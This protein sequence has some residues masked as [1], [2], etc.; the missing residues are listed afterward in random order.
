MANVDPP[1]H[2]VSPATG[3]RQ[4]TDVFVL[5]HVAA[6][7]RGYFKSVIVELTEKSVQ[8][9]ASLRNMMRYLASRVAHYSEFHR[10]A[11]FAGNLDHLKVAYANSGAETK[12]ILSRQF[13]A[14]VNQ[15]TMRNGVTKETFANRLEDD[16]SAVLS[17][18]QLPHA[19]LRVLDLPSS[20][21]IACIRSLAQLQER[22]QIASY[23]LGDK[24]HAIL[25]DPLRHCV[26]DDHGN[27]LQVGFNHVFFSAHRVGVSGSRYT[28]LTKVLAFP[29]RVIAWYLRK[30]FRFN[31]DAPHKRLLVVHPAVEQLLGQSAFSLQEIDVFQPIP[32]RYELI[33]SFN[34]LSLYYF[35]SDAI[36]VGVKNLAASLTEG[37]FLI[38]GT[39][40]SVA[41]FQKSEG[42]LIVRFRQGN[43]ESL[44]VPEI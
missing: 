39:W 23:V 5:Q 32:D 33:L 21:G 42:S 43:W 30:R 40:E 6:S 16:L 25:Y 7:F 13:D 2:S 1:V 31:P 3:C 36:S 24:F 28:F 22:Y 27:L 12:Q 10:I 37:G 29:H 9:G 15:L 26:F 35:T 41:A 14:I 20:T 17:A 38:L 4:P 18:I 44:G 34:L 8:A 19:K 11:H